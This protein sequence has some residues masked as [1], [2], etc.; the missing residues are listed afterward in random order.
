VVVGTIGWGRD[1]SMLISQQ[2]EIEEL[3]L[4]G[5]IED[6]VNKF[7]AYHQQFK[8]LKNVIIKK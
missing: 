1:I 7:L 8:S 4:N 2:S 6:G 3:F 5:K